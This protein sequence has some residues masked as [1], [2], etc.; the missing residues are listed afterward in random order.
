MSA[1]PARRINAFQHRV[2]EDLV[3]GLDPQVQANPRSG[4][5]G[6]GPPA[7]YLAPFRRREICRDLDR[8]SVRRKECLDSL[9]ARDAITT[10][11]EDRDA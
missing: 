10:E 1:S 5:G 2:R 4:I 3:A 8:G 11:A 9:H 7:P 6:K